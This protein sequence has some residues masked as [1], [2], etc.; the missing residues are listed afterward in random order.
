MVS[1]GAA[2]A[3]EFLVKK[4]TAEARATKKN[5]MRVKRKKVVGRHVQQEKKIDPHNRFLQKHYGFEGLRPKKKMTLMFLFLILM[6]FFVGQGLQHFF[7]P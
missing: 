1:L 7:F 5:R 2:P 6:L 3:P 4:K